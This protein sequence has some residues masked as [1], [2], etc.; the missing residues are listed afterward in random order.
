[1]SNHTKFGGV[2]LQN[3]KFMFIWGGENL[4]TTF[5]GVGLKYLGDWKWAVLLVDSYPYESF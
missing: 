3:V 5:L 2:A 1:M 4:T